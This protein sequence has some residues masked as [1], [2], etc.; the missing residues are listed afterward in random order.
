MR[1][2]DKV[3]IVTGGAHGMGEAEARLFAIEGAKILVADILGS[4]AERV[5]ADIR[6]GGGEATAAQID[7]T[8]EAEWKRLIAKAVATYG[9]LDILVNNAGI[10][11]SSVGDPDGLAGWDRIIAVNQTSVF[12]GTKLAAE[13]MAKTG[14]GSIVNISSIMGFVGSASGHPG[15]H[16]SKGQCGSTPKPRPCGTARRASG[17]TPSIPVTCRRC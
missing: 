13:Q 12:L 15:Y 17:L 14:G 5:A 8:S 7:V 16:A 4:D 2:K 10:S 1:L 3:A 9:R 11:G 6:A